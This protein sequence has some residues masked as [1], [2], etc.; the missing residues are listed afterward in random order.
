[1]VSIPLR[2]G[3]FPKFGAAV[4]H[5]ALNGSPLGRFGVSVRVKVSFSFPAPRCFDS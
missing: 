3:A 5:S 4:A 2:G 1:M